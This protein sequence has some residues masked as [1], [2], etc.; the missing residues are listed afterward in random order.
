YD[1]LYLF[2]LTII[3]YLLTSTLF[4]YTTLFRSFKF[5]DAIRHC[6]DIQTFKLVVKTIARKH[7]LHATFMPKPLFGVQG[8]GMHVNM[9]LFQ[10]DQNIFFDQDGDMK[11]SEK[12]YQF[13]AGLIRHAANYTAV[14]NPTVNSYKRLVPGYEAPS[15]IAWSAHNR[16]PLVR[17]P[18]SRGISTR[19]EL[20][21][22]DPTANPYMAV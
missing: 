11:L 1:L 18:F 20:R 14:T 21:S 16:S 7:G 12:A 2:Y 4:P 22:V 10:S 6:D 8:S 5:S 3:R 17:I 19:V 9:S 13:T 15:Y